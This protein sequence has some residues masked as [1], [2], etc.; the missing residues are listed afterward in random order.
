M[1]PD[2]SLLALHRVGFQNA[3]R[4]ADGIRASGSAEALAA[5]DHYRDLLTPEVWRAAESDLAWLEQDGNHLV[6]NDDGD[7]PTYLDEIYDPPVMLF[8]QGRRELLTNHQRLAVVGSRKASHY[9]LRQASTWAESMARQGVVVVSG[10]AMGIDAAAHEGALAAG[11]NTLAVLGTGVD[12]IYPRRNWRLAGRISEC[13]LLLSEFPLGTPAFPGNFPRR[14]RIVTGLSRATLVIEA[15]LRSGSLISARLA[16]NEGRDVMAMP[17]LV[18]NPQA[19]GCHQ[20]LKQ[21]A[22]LVESAEDVLN[23]MGIGALEPVGIATL[24]SLTAVQQ[25][26]VVCLEGGAR[27]IDELVFHLNI[28]IDALSVQL[29]TLEIL[30]VIYS[31]GGRY[32]INPRGPAID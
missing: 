32:A 8:A 31:D 7:Y 27:T 10:L 21:G 19:R 23:E 28:T 24:P 22:L 2:I 3:V 9:G 18:T 11:G 1:E 15:A 25:Q 17:G 29:M 14:N 5:S 20:L 13:G 16:M 12:V 4:L 6:L 30:G 26:L